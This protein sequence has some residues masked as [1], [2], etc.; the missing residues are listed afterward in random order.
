MFNGAQDVME[1]AGA[2]RVRLLPWVAEV[3]RDVDLERRQ[4]HV[5]WGAEW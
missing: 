2:D 1:V 4:I 3:V 5:A